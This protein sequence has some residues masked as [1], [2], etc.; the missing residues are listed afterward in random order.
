[1]HIRILIQAGNLPV[2]EMLRK[3]SHRAAGSAADVDDAK[4]HCRVCR[5]R[6]CRPASGI[7]IPANWNICLV[8][9]NPPGRQRLHSFVSIFFA[10]LLSA[11]LLSAS[12]HRRQV[13][14][15]E[16]NLLPVFIHMQ[17]ALAQ[18]L[19]IEISGI[20][21]RH[22]CDREAV[23]FARFKKSSIFVMSTDSSSQQQV[24]SKSRRSQRRPT[25]SRFFSAGSGP[26][27]QPSP[28]GSV[29]VFPL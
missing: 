17:A 28:S 8:S 13:V 23:A 5:L 24:S 12:F 21:K 10:P 3:P 19:D 22:G 18:A 1:M 15:T 14:C 9:A 11:L 29:S 16:R 6:L 26:Q 7:S 20:L 25:N 27:Q 2:W 4:R